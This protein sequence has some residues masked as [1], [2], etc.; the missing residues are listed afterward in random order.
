MSTLRSSQQS[1]KE[2]STSDSAISLNS[3][4]FNSSNDDGTIGDDSSI[5]D[6]IL[7]WSTKENLILG[8]NLLS[9]VLRGKST[10]K[11]EKSRLVQ[12]IDD[13]IIQLTNLAF[14]STI[15]SAEAMLN[16][17]ASAAVDGSARKKRKLDERK[18]S[19]QRPN[20]MVFNITKLTRINI[21]DQLIANKN[22]VT[23]YD[24]LTNKF[25]NHLVQENNIMINL[26]LDLPFRLIDKSEPSSKNAKQ[27]DSG[28]YSFG[29]KY[30]NLNE[31]KMCPVH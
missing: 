23:Y 11:D 27:H 29:V 1:K 26:L 10:S 30:L 2:Q 20:E 13:L 8:F 12:E 19:E 31:I 3:I 16:H 21:I 22:A 14:E 5:D 4:G 17:E 9:S 28:V 25:K 6:L 18:P 7:E 15:E 24:S